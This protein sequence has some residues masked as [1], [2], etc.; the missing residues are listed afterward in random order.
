MMQDLFQKSP[1]EARSHRFTLSA[2]SMPDG[3]FFWA[4]SS[5]YIGRRNTYTLF[6]RCADRVVSSDSG[7]AAAGSWTIFLACLFTVFTMYGGGFAKHRIPAALAEI[8]SDRKTSGCNSRRPALAAW[9]RRN[10]DR[11]PDHSSSPSCPDR[12][13]GG[14]LAPGASKVHI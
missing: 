1:V 9:Q 4:S 3:R 13:T 5:D 14:A 6:L 2:C 7:I 11:P 10:R 12:A 8:S